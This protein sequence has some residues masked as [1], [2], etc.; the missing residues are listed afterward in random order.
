MTETAAPE[1]RRGPLS[2]FAPL[3]VLL[4]ALLS[5]S[6]GLAELPV[7][8]RDEAR[9]AQA[10]RQM[11]ETGDWVDI[12]FQDQPRHVKPVGVYWMQAAVL[13][14]TG[15]TGT[16]E[17]W[18]HRLPSY[19][20]GAL[21]AMALV[22]AGTPLVGRRQ[23]ALAGVMLATVYMMSAE[24]RTAKTDAT[25]LLTIIL[26]MGAMARAWL[27]GPRGWTVPAIFWTA[28]AAGL[29]VKGPVILLPVLTAAAWVSGRD[30]SSAWMG[31][32]RPLPGLAW[33]LLLALPWF[34]A[35]MLRTDGAFL[36]ASLGGDMAEKLAATGEHSGMPPGLYLIFIW[37]TF[38]P[39][40]LLLP[41]AAVTGWRMRR[42][43]EGAFLLGWIVP[44][45]IVFEAVWTKLIH[46]TL[47][48]YPALMLLAAVPLVAMI[49]GSARFRGWAA[50]AGTVGFAL[51]TAV[52]AVLAIGAPIAFGDGIAFWPTLGGLALTALA[53]LGALAFYRG[54]A[55]R[56]TAALAAAGIAMA[57]TLTAA[58]LPAAR[59]FWVT[60]RLGAA[61]DRLPCLEAPPA[62]PGFGE[63]SVVFRFGT[64]TPDL[65][66]AQ[67]LDW[68][69]EGENRAAWIEPP[70]LPA[71]MQA[72]PGVPDLTEI[73]GTNYTNGGN[74]HLRLYVSP[75]VP[76]SDAPCG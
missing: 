29:L 45:W 4:L 59:E 67:A 47:P 10:S 42:S 64:D 18:P 54:Q 24:A 60:P 22:W 57:W 66:T 46:Y 21:A 75:G 49:E 72:P 76:A 17:I 27:G 61:M 69:A 33:M 52:F 68:L 6:V 32:L 53:I 71:G 19:L 9:Y 56:G 55:A 28:I 58:S 34:V 36:A 37:A 65:S 16:A 5:F 23:A 35:I 2:R 50:H 63:P 3:W 14:A 41:L 20:M 30:R 25:L 73:R 48:V 8:D 70:D 44:T 7:Q 40:T 31:R 15:L 12:R 13:E 43:A 26:A 11:A 51:G 1:G 62:V 38:W 39:W 74:V